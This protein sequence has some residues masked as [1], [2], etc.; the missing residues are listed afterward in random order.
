MRRSMRVA[1]R[2]ASRWACMIFGYFDESGEQE[3]G[4]V[5]V[6]GFIGKKRS[7]EK[8]VREWLQVT[9]GRPLHMKTLRLGSSNAERRYRQRLERLGP[10]PKQVGLRPFVGSVRTKDYKHLTQGTIGELALTGYYVALHALV[11]G[12][13]KSDL[14][15][16]DRIE[17]IFEE[18]K[19]SAV[20][21]EIAF[22]LF[23]Q[24][25]A[26][27]AH[28][29]LSRIAKVSSMEK[30]TKLEASDYL[31]YA[32]LYQ[33]IDPNSQQADLTSPILRAYGRIDHCHAGGVQIRDLI[34]IYL[35]ETGRSELPRIDKDR[36]AFIKQRLK[37]KLGEGGFE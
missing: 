19:E 27:K 30:S 8:Y 6:A 33:L 36:K 16:Q 22:A 7:W 12:V 17:F 1:S 13:L 35:D 28:H 23:R 31:A 37:D 34:Q 21:R 11:D 2:F 9:E 25:P 15:R 4:Y 24:M 5:V 20:A 18:H 32:A 26:H 29:G 14:P 3:D 10:I